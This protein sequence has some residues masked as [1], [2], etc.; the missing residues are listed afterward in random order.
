MRKCRHTCQCCGIIRVP[1]ANPFRLCICRSNVAPGNP[2]SITFADIDGLEVMI[3]RIVGSVIVEHEVM[4]NGDLMVIVP[5]DIQQQTTYGI[6]M[7]G[8]Y[9]GQPWRW[10]ATKVFSIVG[11]NA[12]ISMPGRETFGEE[13]YYIDDILD[14]DTNGDTMV[15]TTHGHVTLVGGVLDIQSTEDCEVTV[16]GDAIV[17]TRKK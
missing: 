11:D 10:N 1:Y 12:D 8:T 16:E 7:T 5:V 3:T 9:N 15:F 6:R 17:F 14:V 13:T 4:E 2:D